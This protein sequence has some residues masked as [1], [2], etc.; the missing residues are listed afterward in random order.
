MEQL[1]TNVI[2]LP[3]RIQIRGMAEAENGSKL[4]HLLVILKPDEEWEGWTF[5]EIKAHGDG[6]IAPKI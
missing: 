5:E 6:P 1:K 3:E 2:I 4:G